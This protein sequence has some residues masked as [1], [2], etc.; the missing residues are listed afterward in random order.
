MGLEKGDRVGV[1]GY[2]FDSY[3]AR[4]ARVKIVA[5][6]PGW[7]ADELWF[8]DEATRES[9]VAAFAGA[10]VRAVVAE[11]VPR[12]ARL[13]GWQQVGRTSCWIRQIR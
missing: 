3:W 1:V 11:R 8:G 13:R 10:G 2:A 6:M 9:I 4:L 5:E 7:D 12:Y